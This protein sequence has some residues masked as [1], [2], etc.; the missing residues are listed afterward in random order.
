MGG[1]P[2]TQ[3][4]DVSVP[5]V[6]DVPVPVWGR[7][8]LL[9]GDFQF[10]VWDAPVPSALTPTVGT[11]A[12]AWGALS[13]VQGHPEPS[14]GDSRR[15]LS[16][17]GVH[18]HPGGIPA[19][20]TCPKAITPTPQPKHGQPAVPP[21]CPITRGTGGGL[22]PSRAAVLTLS[23]LP[24]GPSTTLNVLVTAPASG[25]TRPAV[26]VLQCSQCSVSITSPCPELIVLTVSAAGTAPWEHSLGGAQ[27]GWGHPRGAWGAHGGRRC[28]LPLPRADAPGPRRRI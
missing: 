24:Q 8:G 17:C 16:H 9:C 22:C 11:L 21:C 28:P 7:P 15:V 20:L 13:L 14:S 19:S 3:G 5:G 12:A 26:L 25:C 4:G 1:D 27:R 6:G 18:E 2:G 10:P 23:L